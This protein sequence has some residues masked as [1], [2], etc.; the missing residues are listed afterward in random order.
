MERSIW[1]VPVDQPG[2]PRLWQIRSG[3]HLDGRYWERP[4][5]APTTEDRALVML[6]FLQ[7]RSASR[8]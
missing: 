3:T 6:R 2:L 1:A 5:G 4:Y 7:V 8:G